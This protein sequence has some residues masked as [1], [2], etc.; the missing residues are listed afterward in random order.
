METSPPGRAADGF[1]VSILGVPVV[2]KAILPFSYSYHPKQ[3]EH[4]RFAC[5]IAGLK[6]AATKAG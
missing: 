2:F 5:Q 4:E 6:A 1:T 3:S